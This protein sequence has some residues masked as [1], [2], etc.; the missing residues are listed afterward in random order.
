MN[1]RKNSKLVRLPKKLSTLIR[2]AVLDVREQLA[3]GVRMDM[4]AWLVRKDKRNPKV[5]DNICTMCLGGA[6][7]LGELAGDNTFGELVAKA[8]FGKSEE[9]D[10]LY[11]LNTLRCGNII[12][13][14]ILYNP[15]LGVDDEL[16]AKVKA[17]YTYNAGIYHGLQTR[18]QSYAMCRYL[19]RLACKLEELGL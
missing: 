12:D 1:S 2:V 7:L 10:A 13:A 18:K 4:E 5:T 15:S 6:I 14:V 16:F 8:E 9:L 3:L 17:I 11:A 19:V